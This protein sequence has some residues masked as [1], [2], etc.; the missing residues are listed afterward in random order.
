MNKKVG[1]VGASGWL[2]SELSDALLDQGVE[3]VGFSRQKRE[4]DKISWQ[5]WNTQ[6]VPD[7]TGLD[8]VVNLAGESVAQRWSEGKKKKFYE[9]RVTLSRYVAEGV[10]LAKVPVLLNSSAVGFYGDR[11]DEALTEESHAGKNYFSDLCDEW[12]KVTVCEHARV[13][14]LRTGFVLGK[15]GPAWDQMSKVF[16]L[17]L[18]GRLGNGQQWMPW[19]HVK[20]E[21]QAIIH[22]LENEISGPVNLAA[23]QS[24]RNLSF[25]QKISKALKRPAI[26]PV[27]AFMLKLVLGDFAEEGVLAS[28]RVIPKALQ[29][30]GFQFTYPAFEAALEDLA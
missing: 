21:I 9:S 16:R 11:G 18:G 20:D 12:E 28:L 15:G 19:I 8:A 5:V 13:V 2:G 1:V 6:S 27:P 26:F 17:G 23:P 10:D 7:F 24:E 22:C 29:D 4:E 14:Y 25:T 3:V 30:S